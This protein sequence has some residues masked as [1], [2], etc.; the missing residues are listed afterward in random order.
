MTN[1]P[2][3]EELAALVREDRERLA[4]TTA[5]LAA[6]ADLKAAVRRSPLPFAL[7]AISAAAIVAGL[8][9]LRRRR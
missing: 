9:L 6:K 5:A 4:R 8:I 2:S 1:E 7:A 3:I